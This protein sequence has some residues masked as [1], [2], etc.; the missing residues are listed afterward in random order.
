LAATVKPAPFAAVPVMEIVDAFAQFGVHVTVGAACTSPTSN[1]DTTEV[2]VQRWRTNVSVEPEVCV[3]QEA[4]KIVPPSVHDNVT[5]ALL[6]VPHGEGSGAVTVWADSASVVKRE[7][8]ARIDVSSAKLPVACSPWEM[9][10]VAAAAS[11][12]MISPSTVTETTNS[13]SV[14]P[15]IDLAPR[16]R[17]RQRIRPAI[18]A[19]A[20]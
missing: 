10:N 3:D 7:I 2:P 19:L 1:V 8:T 9:K 4:R 12:P 20:S 5:S 18:T 17:A 13:M 11:G 16:A 6:P 14:N 15:R